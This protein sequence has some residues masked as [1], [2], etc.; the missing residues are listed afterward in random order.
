MDAAQR[1][2]Y[3]RLAEIQSKNFDDLLSNIVSGS[4]LS[5]DIENAEM[6]TKDL[7]TLVDVSVSE[8][9]VTDYRSRSLRVCACL[10]GV[11]SGGG[12]AGRAAMTA[13]VCARVHG[14]HSTLICSKAS[15]V[16]STCS[17]VDLE[18]KNSLLARMQRLRL[19]I[20]GC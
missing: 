3:R 13:Y 12:L 1:A 16:S 20:Y 6:A 15:A 17:Y 8:L 5:L 2:G 7:V 11:R 14:A 9:I 10:H 18:R 4:A 19:L